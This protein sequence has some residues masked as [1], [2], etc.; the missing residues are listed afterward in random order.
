MIW[1]LKSLLVLTGRRWFLAN[2]LASKVTA[3][4]HTMKTNPCT[5][6]KLMYH[7]GAHELLGGSC[8]FS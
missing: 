8:V 1:L 4:A 3:S 2:G 7:S 6:L 5:H